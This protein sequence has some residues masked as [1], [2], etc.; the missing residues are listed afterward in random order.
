MKKLLWT[1]AALLLAI[2]LLL[3]GKNTLDQSRQSKV[4][5]DRVLN[6]YNWGDY[7]D[8]QLLKDFEHET[9]YRVNYQTFDS[10]EAMFTKIKQGGTSYDLTVPSDYMV[11][12]L[13]DEGLLAP[14]DKNK[15]TD[16]D[17]LNPRF[18]NQSFDPG[19]RYSL[20]Y[21]WGTL[22]I[23]YNKKQVDGRQLRTW[24]DLW[25]PRYRKQILLVDSA[26]DILGLTLLSQGKSVNDQNAADL[27]AA[28]G[29]LTALMP[30]VKAI[31]ADELKLYMAQ[32]EANIG[33][34][35]S[36]EAKQAMEKNPDLAYLVPEGG[37][38]LWL[39]NLAIPKNAKH[40]EA[41]YALINF[42]NRP[43]NAARNAEY[44]G[45]ATPNLGAYKRL[46]QSV[47]NDQAFYPK[48]SILDQLQVYQNFN[49]AWTERYNDAFLEFK[50]SR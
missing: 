50:M 2:G 44:I 29:R 33:V 22:G 14:L 42:L 3:L 21:F 16:L 15:L 9:G 27:A 17:Q 20:P 10:N 41:A 28:K 48:A 32:G 23:L 37:A 24:S 35:Y 25:S 49:Q 39:D 45:Y 46:P 43:E 36:G 13:K 8:P 12:K 30:N 26:R 7:I 5:G 19:N 34:T 47:R 31:V 18:L 40:K 1:T 38:N 6:F 4:A 11:Q